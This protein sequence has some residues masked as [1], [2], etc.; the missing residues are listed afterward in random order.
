MYKRFCW[1][2]IIEIWSPCEKCECISD[3]ARFCWW[4]KKW[5]RKSANVSILWRSRCKKSATVSAFWKSEFWPHIKN[6]NENQGFACDAEKCE[7]TMKNQWFQW[8]SFEQCEC[9][10]DLAHRGAK[11][12]NVSAIVFIEWQ[13]LMCSLRFY[14]SACECISVADGRLATTHGF[15]N[16]F[17]FGVRVYQRC[18]WSTS[19]NSW[20]L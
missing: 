14:R 12:V 13:Q 15:C 8:K 11:S 2:S 10:S 20:V 19:K 6:P 7:C 9:I 4:M 16:I 1:F 5:Y 3:F 17:Q 18:G